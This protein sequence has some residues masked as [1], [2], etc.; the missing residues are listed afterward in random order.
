VSLGF[1]GLS[2]PTSPFAQAPTFGQTDDQ[3]IQGVGFEQDL[4][5]DPT[6]AKRVYTS[7]PGSLSSDTSW[8]WHSED[9]GKTIKWVT[10][11]G[12]GGEADLVARRGDTELAV[13]LGRPPLLHEPDGPELQWGPLG[14]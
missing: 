10:G 4:R 1:V 3:R 5:L 2:L 8:I 7:V 12:Q 9:S 6:N 11:D 14:Q 13:D